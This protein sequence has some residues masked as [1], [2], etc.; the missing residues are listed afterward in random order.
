[1][2]VHRARG[3]VTFAE[4]DASGR[5]HYTAA[6]RW[7]EDAEH[8]LYRSLGLPVAGFPR[9][10]VSATFERPLVDGDEYVVELSVERLGTSSITYAWRIVH[11]VGVAVTGS[12]TVVHVDASGRPAAVPDPLRTS[13]ESLVGGSPSGHHS[14][15]PRSP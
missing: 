5:F 4:T 7:A 3:V 13:L 14:A 9:R 2:S 11:E 8:E 1:M 10:T 12:H 6:L 15:A